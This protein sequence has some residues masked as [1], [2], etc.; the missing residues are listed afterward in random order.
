[1]RLD[2]EKKNLFIFELK[3]ILIAISSFVFAFSMILQN[4]S[5]GFVYYGL[6]LPIIIIISSF[7]TTLV[8]LSIIF[9]G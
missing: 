3:I 6:T 5:T 4:Y 7:T 8:G 9:G 1:M 2:K